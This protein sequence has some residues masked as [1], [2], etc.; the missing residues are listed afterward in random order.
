[1]PMVAFSDAGRQLFSASSMW[2]SVALT[3]AVAVVVRARPVRVGAALTLALLVF[4]FAVPTAIG[5]NALRLPMLFAIPLAV[6]YSRW[7]WW[8]LAPA[9]ALMFWLQP[10]ILVDDVRHAGSPET[11]A[12]FYRPLLAELDTLGPLGRIEVV[13][14]RDHWESVHVA[15]AVPLARGWLRQVDTRRNPPFYPAGRLTAAEYGDWLRDNAVS[16]VAVAP[17]QPLDVYGRSEAAVIA[18]RPDYLT[19]VWQ[20]A[21]WQLYRVEGARP[22]VTGGVLVRAAPDRITVDVTDPRGA[23]IRVRWSRWLTATGGACVS[24]APGGWVTLV[25]P[26]P[27]RYSLT[28]GFG[29][30]CRTPA[31]GR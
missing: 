7:R 27:G 12:G 20:G 31:T 16:Y 18:G 5:S 24:E 4:A 9:L 19:P 30:T 23:T 15:D 8:A 11:T 3:V 14:L 10:P 28:S 25:P 21:D 13:P 17:G 1:V 26:A 6:G 22:F 29:G 2:L